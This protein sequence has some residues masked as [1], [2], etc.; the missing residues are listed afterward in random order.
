MPDPPPSLG[1]ALSRIAP[2]DATAAAGGLLV[3]I[4][5]SGPWVSSPFGSAAGTSG[6]GIFSL[7]LGIIVIVL[8]FFAPRTRPWLVALGGLLTV[9]AVAELIH[10]HN[11]INDVTVFGSHV[12]STGWGLYAFLIGALV[13]LAA[14]LYPVWLKRSG[15]ARA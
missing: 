13:V 9:F 11:R 10:V 14:A 12:A 6:D 1:Q 3:A 5:S 15:L 7:I 4:G 8:A 2:S